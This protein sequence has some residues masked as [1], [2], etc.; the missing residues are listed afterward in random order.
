MMG[1]EQK[2]DP[3][4]LAAVLAS[5]VKSDAGTH[6]N[7]IWSI[8]NQYSAASSPGSGARCFFPKTV[9]NQRCIFPARKAQ[10]EKSAG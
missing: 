4:I 2:R 5:R 1:T 10:H 7:L 9:L 6:V 8:T 3:T